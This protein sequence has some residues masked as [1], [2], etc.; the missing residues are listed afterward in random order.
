M[1][2]SVF[3][4]NDPA[5][6]ATA[7]QTLAG[8]VGTPAWSAL[9]Q[10]AQ[11]LHEKALERDVTSAEH[12]AQINGQRRGMR[13]LLTEAERLA[14]EGVVSSNVSDIGREIAVSIGT[15]PV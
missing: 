11:H 3:D 1:P 14:R 8:I 13:S 10:L 6:R 4:Y 2:R 7:G 12:I 9:Q 15:G 5:D